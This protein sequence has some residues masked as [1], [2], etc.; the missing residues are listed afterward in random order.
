MTTSKALSL[1]WVRMSVGVM[2]VSACLIFSCF[3]AYRRGR[4]AG[5]R[6]ASALGHEAAF[7]ASLSAL[8]NLRGG[9][10]AKAID[11][12][13]AFCYASAVALLEQPSLR[14]NVVGGWFRADLL[15]YRSRY[16]NAAGKQYP[17]EKRLDELLRAR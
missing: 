7:V 15:N 11:N 14:S 8:Q 3:V 5:Y 12:L 13:E 2:L 10:S 6:E 1:P 4:A 16:G 9:D 17:T